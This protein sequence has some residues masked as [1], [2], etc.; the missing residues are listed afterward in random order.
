LGKY[1]RKSSNKLSRRFY[2][3]KNSG[4]FIIKIHREKQAEKQNKNPAYSVNIP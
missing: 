3:N 4:F 1:T 2:T